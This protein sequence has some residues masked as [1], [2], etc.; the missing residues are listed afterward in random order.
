MTKKGN[1]PSPDAVIAWLQAEGQN[2]EKPLRERMLRMAMREKALTDL[3]WLNTEILGFTECYEPFHRPVCDFV[4][5]PGVRKLILL[6]RDHFK[7]SI[8]TV[9]YGV[10]SILRDPDI[11]ILISNATEDLA[12]EF[13]GNI[14]I[15]FRDNDKLINLFP[16]FRLTDKRFTKGKFT[17]PNRVRVWREATVE[18]VGVGTN[19]V[20]RHY[21]K[22][23]KDDIVSLDCLESEANNLKVKNWDG[24]SEALFNRRRKHEEE[25]M[26]LIIGTRWGARDLY[27]D[28]IDSKKYQTMIMGLKDEE[29]GQYHFPT[30]F[31]EKAEEEIKDKMFPLP[32]GRFLFYSQYYNVAINPENQ[33]FKDEMFIEKERDEIA[34]QIAGCRKYLLVDPAQTKKS[35]SDPSGIIIVGVTPSGQWI[36]LEIINRKTDPDDL[37]KLVYDLASREKGRHKDIYRI[38]FESAGLQNTYRSN[39]RM[40]GEM[41]GETLPGFIKSKTTTKS[42]KEDRID[43]L[44]PL[45]EQ[46]RVWFI[47]GLHG[48]SALKGQ[49]LSHRNNPKH[50]DLMDA[51]ASLVPFAK[52][53][54]APGEETPESVPDPDK[55]PPLTL[56]RLKEISKMQAMKRKAEMGGSSLREQYQ[57]AAPSFRSW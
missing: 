35:W 30:R 23:F 6:P 27:G 15:H 4:T 10:Q 26:D 19:I 3:Y 31:D 37:V 18:S 28:L 43:A 21:D 7:S 16:E 50:D 36:I 2:I 39:L 45:F 47:K 48:N 38:V 12:I 29:S 49:L 1:S 54:H 5:A 11:R 25:V 41:H 57:K 13:C 51:L 40:Y 52:A 46:G 24:A 14:Q 33:I 34:D 17:V 44:Q 32:G 53:S 55:L 56:S 42:S 9:G 22:I 20:G 8:I